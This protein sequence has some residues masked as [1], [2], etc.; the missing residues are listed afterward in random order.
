MDEG[1]IGKV[2]FIESHFSF[3]LKDLDNVRLIKDLAGGCTYDIG[4]YNIN[5]IRYIAGSEPHFVFATGEIGEKSGVDE[6]S[7]AVM[8][9]KD[10]LKAVS[11][12]SFNSFERSEYT[13]VGETGIISFLFCLIAKVK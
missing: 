5:I 10:G 12:C 11:N 3:I 6:S 2:N 1:V 4:C 8:E 9:F 7:C 13:I